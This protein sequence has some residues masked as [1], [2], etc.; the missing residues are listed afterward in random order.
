MI[1]RPTRTVA[2]RAIVVTPLRAVKY[3]AV[4]SFLCLFALGAGAVSMLPWLYRSQVFLGE[5]NRADIDQM[6]KVGIRLAM[7]L[8]TCDTKLEAA[9]I[10][11]PL[12]QKNVGGE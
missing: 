2:E 4:W 3:F 5:R 10:R 1:S 9:Q 7:E 8:Q 11:C 6:E 12:K